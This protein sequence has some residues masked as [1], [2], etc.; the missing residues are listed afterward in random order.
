MVTETWLNSEAEPS[1]SRIRGYSPWFRNDCQGRQGGVALCFKEGVQA[2]RLEIEIPPTLEAMFLR[3]ALA[4]GTALLLCVMCRSPKQEPAPLHFLTETL[5]VLLTRHRY[6]NVL[7]VGGL[8]SPSQG[9]CLRKS[10]DGTGSYRPCYLPNPRAW[11]DAESCHHRPERGISHLPS[12]Q[13]S[14]KLGSPRYPDLGRHGRC[15]A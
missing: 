11:G 2:Q 5:D 12:A 13:T 3:V 4:D 9:S 14:G 8:E 10:S 15:T 7:I 1:F 6:R